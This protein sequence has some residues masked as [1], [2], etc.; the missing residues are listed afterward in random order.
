MDLGL[1][2]KVALIT[3]A[4][5]G[6][7][8]AAAQRLAAEGASLMLV[9]RSRD[10]LD[11]LAAEI[12]HNYHVPVKSWAGDL[13]Q[14]ES[15]ATAAD[16]A[17]NAYGRID[18]FAASAGASQGGIFWE[19]PDRVWEDSFT[20][21]F[22]ATIR[23]M[24]AVIPHMRSQNYGRIVLVVGNT[25][26][27][28]QPRLLPGAAANAA[29]LAVIKGL[30]DEVAKDGIVINAVNPGPTRTERWSG[31]M[32]AAAISRGISA[33][34][35]EAEYVRD[36][37]MGRLGEP[38]EIARLITFLASDAAGNMTGTSVTADGG[39]TRAIA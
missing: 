1:A 9:A 22:M 23:M 28:P 25:G 21:K 13:S 39:W 24:K 10:K 7:G 29:L 8:A 35:V 19:M 12:A 27:Q 17:M 11:A 31:L 36:I 6:I 2:G 38:D 5:K 16:A 4:S 37:P 32:E 3:G 15:A 14:D 30:A 26:R 33:A 20:L 18:I 34:A